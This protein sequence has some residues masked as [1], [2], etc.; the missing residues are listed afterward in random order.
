MLC[1]RIDYY[2]KGSVQPRIERA[3]R[4]VYPSRRCMFAFT[5][6]CLSVCVEGMRARASVFMCVF[7]FHVADFVVVVV[8][9]G[10]RGG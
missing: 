2:R 6:M 1:M 3:Q 5:P 4:L 7:R 10:G 8:G 9:D